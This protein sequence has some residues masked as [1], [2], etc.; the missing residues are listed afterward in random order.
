MTILAAQNLFR[1]GLMAMVE[2]RHAEAADLFKSAMTMETW[3]GTRQ[4]QVRCLSYYGINIA[5]ANRPSQEAFDA[6]TRAIRIEPRDPDLYLNLGRLLAMSGRKTKALAMLE[7]GLKLAPQHK[8]LK[9]EIAKYD[10]RLPPVLPF[11]DRSHRL[12]Q[13]LGR[14]RAGILI[15]AAVDGPRSGSATTS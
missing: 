6:C 10:R 3:R 7:R 11:L 2:G 1:N 12:N 15:K 14:L 13:L 5:L 8:A 9:L 4:Q